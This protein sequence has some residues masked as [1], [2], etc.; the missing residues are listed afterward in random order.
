MKRRIIKID[1]NK[2]DGCGLCIPECPE[3]AIQIIDGKARLVSDFFCD[4][5]GACIKDCPKGAI[6][7]EEREAEPYD[8][9]RVMENIIPKGINTIKAHL[10]HLSDHGEIKFLK[11]ATELLKE[12]G[13]YVDMED[14]TSISCGC[15]TSDTT[16]FKREKYGKEES[17]DIKSVPSLLENWP[18]Q[19][20]LISPNMP[21]FKNQDILLAADCTPFACRDF[22]NLFLRNKLLIVACP[23]L[24]ADKE[25]YIEKIKELVDNAKINTLTVVIMEVPCCRGFLSI[26]QEGIKKAQ[27]RVPL[28]LIVVSIKG[29]VLSEDWI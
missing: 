7:T 9:K 10:K 24:D 11:E 8:E 3:G 28:K 14:S 27:R 25:S 21:F 26:A 15:S 17:S 29:E 12:K 2:C 6:S 16:L 13:I 23:K 19:L 4:G 1:E 20:H 5:L 22:H 18:I